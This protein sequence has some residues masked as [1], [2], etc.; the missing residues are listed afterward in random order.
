LKHHSTA[1]PIRAEAD[2]RHEGEHDAIE[3]ELDPVRFAHVL[4]HR[5]EPAYASHR[6]RQPDCAGGGQRE[7]GGELQK[8]E[9]EPDVLPHTHTN[10]SVDEWKP[11]DWVQAKDSSRLAMPLNARA[12]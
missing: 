6:E 12:A 4:R 9:C 5:V 11:Y 1:C 7:P 2:G 8:A 3:R 10:L